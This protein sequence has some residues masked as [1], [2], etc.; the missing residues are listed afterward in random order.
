MSFSI[1]LATLADSDALVEMRE[2]FALEE[3]PLG[4]LRPDYETDM[5]VYLA[6]GLDSG[7]LKGWVAEIDGEVV[8]HAFL[9]LVGKVPRPTRVNRRIAYLTNVYTRPAERGSGIGAELL[10]AVTAWAESSD[11]ELIFVWPSEVSTAFYGRSGFRSP[12]DLL[13]WEAAPEQRD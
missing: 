1:R 10:A 7:R 6:E 5:R 8:S 3:E 13:V 12:T 9:V 11:V 4:G 2:A